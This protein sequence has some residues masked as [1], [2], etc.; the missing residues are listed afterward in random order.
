MILQQK[1]NYLIQIGFKTINFHYFMYH[2][3]ISHF[4]PQEYHALCFIRRKL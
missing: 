3:K 2:K 1:P 4:D